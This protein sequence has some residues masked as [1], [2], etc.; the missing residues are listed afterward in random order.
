[1]DLTWLPYVI[2]AVLVAGGVWV[3]FGRT[4]ADAN[5]GRGP[6]DPPR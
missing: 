3:T 2:V 1:M 4:R 6:V 5:S